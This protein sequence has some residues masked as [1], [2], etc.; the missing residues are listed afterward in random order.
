MLLVQGLPMWICLS[1]EWSPPVVP[2]LLACRVIA[3]MIG[4]KFSGKAT[5]DDE[6]SISM[7]SAGTVKCCIGMPIALISAKPEVE[8]LPDGRVT[9]VFVV[10]YLYL[11]AIFMYEAYS[12]E[13]GLVSALPVI[14]VACAILRWT[15]Y[16]LNFRAPLDIRGCL[17][18]GRW[19]IPAYDKVALTP[20]LAITVTLGLCGLTPNANVK[21]L[22]FGM[23]SLTGF[24]FP[25][26]RWAEFS[27][28]V[29]D[30]AKTA[31]L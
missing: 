7:F 6:S 20:L 5:L 9:A 10:A 30:W 31:Y 18:T 27:R 2:T 14:V 12:G 4:L 15:G 16:V 13:L 28:L 1:W 21:P 19:V 11:G 22:W 25:D 24:T 26:E 3:Y 23:A 29:T 17:K 8:I